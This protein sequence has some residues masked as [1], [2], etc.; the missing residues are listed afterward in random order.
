M[1]TLK[2]KSTAKYTFI[3][4]VEHHDIR[5]TQ[6][7]NSDKWIEF[8]YLEEGYLTQFK[9]EL[10]NKNKNSIRVQIYIYDES[11]NTYIL[12]TALTVK[13]FTANEILSAYLVQ[14]EKEHKND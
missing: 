8:E 6:I 9:A 10:K 13:E 14:V 1:E 7:S 5:D 12:E 3:A 2:D 4:E 11:S